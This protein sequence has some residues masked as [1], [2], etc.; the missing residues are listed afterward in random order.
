MQRFVGS[1]RA[2]LIKRGV[3]TSVLLVNQSATDVYLD[4][5]ANQLMAVAP[6]V[7]PTVGIKLAANGGQVQWQP[8]VG[9]EIWGRAVADTF[10]EL[11][12]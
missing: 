1:T 12:P 10:I 4:S 11:Q 5:S 7:V 6:A 2:T 8:Y 9:S 3:T